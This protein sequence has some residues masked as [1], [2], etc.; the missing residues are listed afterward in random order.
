MAWIDAVPVSAVVLAGG[1]SRRLGGRD[2][3]LIPLGYRPLAGWVSDRI[4]GQVAEVLVSAN[5][6]LGDYAVLGHTVVPD[7]L[8]GRLGPLAGLLAAART[9]R[10]EWLLTLPCDAP[11]VPLDL[12]RR[13]FLQAR[14]TDAALLRAEDETGVHY[15]VMLVH[16][17]LL[18][19]LEIYVEAGGREVRAWQDRHAP[20]S[21]RFDDD[22]YA[23]LNINTPEDLRV[24][25][26]VAPR[27]VESQA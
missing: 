6:N 19:D 18:A 8:P 11:F 20:L 17:R 24:A 25:E 22:P 1:L 2:K 12:A 21:V 16:R 4:A 7:Y 14:D 10:M 15:A 13:L 3:G 5:R 9:A 27:Y 23:F 26:R